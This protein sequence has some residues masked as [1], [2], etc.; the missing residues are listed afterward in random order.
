MSHHVFTEKQW[1]Q[2]ASMRQDK[3]F[4]MFIVKWAYNALDRDT[5]RE[6]LQTQSIVVIDA[7]TLDQ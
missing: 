5:V 7:E 1:Q 2:L 4:V 6:L 3:E